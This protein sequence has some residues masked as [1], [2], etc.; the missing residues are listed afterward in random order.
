MA[1]PK[2]AAPQVI[3]PKNRS[4]TADPKKIAKLMR[5]L[6]VKAEVIAVTTVV[7]DDQK[8]RV[9]NGRH[10]PVRL[11]HWLFRGD[12]KLKDA[13]GD[14]IRVT[15][16]KHGGRRHQRA[17]AKSLIHEIAQL[18]Q[19]HR[20][21]RLIWWGWLIMLV[22]T[23]AGAVFG[24]HLGIWLPWPAVLGALDGYYIGCL[25]APHLRQARQAS[26][27]FSIEELDRL[28]F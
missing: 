18:S 28:L 15:L 2:P 3:G 12:P 5:Q 25:L 1:N 11:A 20:D 24:Y 27:S 23:I 4:I 14:V 16:V 10:Y 9:T 17:V 13:P 19:Y 6:G 26:N 8:R 21:R 22:M 7:F